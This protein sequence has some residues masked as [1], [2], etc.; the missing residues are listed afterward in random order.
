MRLGQVF[1]Y[2]R[3]ALLHRGFRSKV[4]EAV[5][6]KQPDTA[7]PQVCPSRKG[8]PLCH[9]FPES[10]GMFS[11]ATARCRGLPDVEVKEMIYD[12]VLGGEGTALSDWALTVGGWKLVVKRSR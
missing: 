1:W 10:R 12:Q 9:T 6:A 7:A 4:A 5:I 2:D 8:L 11:V 3:I